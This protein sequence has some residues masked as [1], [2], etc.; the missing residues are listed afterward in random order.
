MRIKEM[1][2]FTSAASA[3]PCGACRQVLREFGPE[4]RVTFPL[5]GEVQTATVLELLPLPFRLT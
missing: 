2:I 4:A 3:P 5:K 1:A